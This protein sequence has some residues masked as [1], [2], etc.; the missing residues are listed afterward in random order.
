MGC[1]VYIP[2]S[3]STVSHTYNK[4][5]TSTASV[6]HLQGVSHIYS[7]CHTPT[8]S[9]T[10]WQQVSH[11]DSKYHT[12]TASVTH[13]QQVSHTDSKCHTL[14][15]NVTHWQQVSHLQGGREGDR[16]TQTV[17]IWHPGG[18]NQEILIRD[19]FSVPFAAAEAASVFWHSPCTKG[20]PRPG[21]ITQLVTARICNVLQECL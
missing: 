6:T 2:L 8:A 9:V 11:T 15:A 3:R 7:E 14:T 13:W 17:V 12:L 1:N 10:H 19:T 20:V 16:C 18:L 4:C 21:I 5:H